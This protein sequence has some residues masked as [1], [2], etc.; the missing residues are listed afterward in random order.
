MVLLRVRFLALLY[1]SDMPQAVN[2]MLILFADDT[3]LIFTALNL[4]SLT[5]IM[6]KELQNLSIW[7]DSN[8]LAVNPSK[9]NFLIIPP[10]LNKPFPQTNVFLNNIFIPQC[11]S[12]KYLGLTIDM[13]LNFGFHISNIAYKISRTVGIIFK[14]RHYLPETA[15]LKI[16]YAQ[17]H[18]HLL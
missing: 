13:Y 15:L 2:C 9:S 11:I 6:N 7:F 8:K 14:I 16:Y 5:T 4:A 3:C 12:I 17:I 10:K 18:F 1:V